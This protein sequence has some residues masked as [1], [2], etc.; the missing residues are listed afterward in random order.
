MPHLRTKCPHPLH[1]PPLVEAAALPSHGLRDTRHTGATAGSPG[2]TQ[3]T[4]V[5]GGTGLAIEVGEGVVGAV[6]GVLGGEAIM[7]PRGS[8]LSTK[9]TVL[10]A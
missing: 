6:G 2:G 7:P 10:W 9:N 5:M 8:S 3:T 1:H 4:E